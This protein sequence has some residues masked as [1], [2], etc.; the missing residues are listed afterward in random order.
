[1]TTTANTSK[2][3]TKEEIQNLLKNNTGF[4]VRSLVKI[5]QYQTADEQSTQTTAEYNGV[6]FNGF[7]AEIMS[8]FAV[9]FME[10]NY[11]SEKQVAIVKKRIY[12]YAGQLTKIANGNV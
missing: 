11:L 9:Y 3:W 12:K 5:Y 7:D 6:G 8:K 2:I 10:N 1:M 4:A